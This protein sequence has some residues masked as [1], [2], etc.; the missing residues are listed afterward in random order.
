MQGLF[1]ANAFVTQQ[2]TCINNSVFGS[3]VL[4]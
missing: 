1:F 2:G 3:G 4:S